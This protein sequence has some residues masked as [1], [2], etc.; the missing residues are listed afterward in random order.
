VGIH[1]LAFRFPD[2]SDHGPALIAAGIND[3]I[4]AAAIHFSSSSIRRPIAGQNL[5]NP[6]ENIRMEL[7]TQRNGIAAA[8][9]KVTLNGKRFS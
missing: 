2:P 6:C 4:G 9:A 5:S 7:R 3:A 8:C 1:W